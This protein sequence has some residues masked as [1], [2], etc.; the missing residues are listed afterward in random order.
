[1]YVTPLPA[2]P[3]VEQYRK[4]A[5]ELQKSRQSSDSASSTLADAQFTI[6]REHGF[7]S[8]PKFVRHINGLRQGSVRRFELAA[9]AIVDGDLD[10]LTTLVR[11]RPDLVRERS[12]RRHRATLLHYVA[13]NGVEDFRQRTPAN[14]VPI[15]QLL[16][17]AGA[18]PDATSNSYGGKDTT[19][20]LVVSSD[21][22]GRA[23]LQAGLVDALVDSG[24]A[25][26][27][28]DDDGDPLVTALAFRW[29]LA[30]DALVRRGARVDTVLAAAG[31][32]RLDV[33]R[34]FIAEDGTARS[35]VRLAP[36]WPRLPR[37]PRQHVE[38]ALI[39]AAVFGHADVVEFLCAQR[40]H[41]SAADHFG[42]TA[43]HW[44]ATGG[45]VEVVDLLVRRGLPIERRD[46]Q[47]DAT[48]LGCAVWG[49]KERKAAGDILGVIDRLLAA[50]AD[51]SVVSTPTGNS[52]LDRRLRP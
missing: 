43:L 12:T 41:I 5:K 34:G 25:V 30:A 17:R 10:L 32:G 11:D 39:W 19:L 18:A 22:P 20:G 50:G 37:D 46:N 35:R 45:H 28:I 15:A 27:G 7:D 33:V 51:T 26:N 38:L 44:A 8:W 36:T 4:R 1:M 23:G 2:R 47:F 49:A 16:L 9:D 40:I 29:P 3:N 52:E 31:L 13:A 24:A 14:I 6:A 42:L 21:H 48:V